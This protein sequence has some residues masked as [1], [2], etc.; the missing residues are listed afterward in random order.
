V[1]A[2]PLVVSLL[3]SQYVRTHATA[4]DT[5]TPALWWVEKTDIT[6][7]QNETGNPATPGDTEFTAIEKS[8]ATW[9][10][11]L[12]ACGSLT[13]TEGART[14]SREVG[15]VQDGGVNQN[16]VVFREKRCS[17]IVS[18]SDACWTTE[19]CGSRYDCWD[20]ASNAI[21]ITT[22]SYDPETGEIVD[23]DIELNAPTFTFTTVDTPA[24][25]SP[26]Y[27]YT[28]VATDVQNTVTHEVGHLLGL[29]HNTIAGSTMNPQA[30]PGELSKRVLDTGSKQ[31]ICDV[32][33]TGKPTVTTVLRPVSS[34]LGH[35]ATGCSAAPG[36]WAALSLLLLGLRRRSA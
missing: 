7:H 9:Q 34:T 19:D 3:L 31:F 23:S 12:A 18:A 13:L 30:D 25:I 24:C 22:T 35:V 33:P 21:A 17:G 8:F 36:T 6:W 28:C 16:I 15:Y 11:Q 5:S 2:A 32:Y 20:H 4:G 27:A 14:A 10:T 29:A 1:I 26:N